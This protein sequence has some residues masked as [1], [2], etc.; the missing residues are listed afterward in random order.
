MLSIDNNVMVQANTGS[1]TA[2]STGDASIQTGNAYANA[3]VV[4][5]ANTN[6]VDSNYVMMV[7]NNYG[8]LNGDIVLPN[9]AFFAHFLAQAHAT[10]NSGTSVLSLDNNNQGQV[11]STV[12]T[13]AA[14]GNNS[15]TTTN[16]DGTTIQT[17]NSVSGS[18][19]VNQVNQNVVGGGNAVAIVFHVYGKWTGKTF[20]AP[21]Q[22]MW[23]G[24]PVSI[25]FF[26]DPAAVNAATDNL[27]NISSDNTATVNNNV[28]VNAG[29][30]N[31][32]AAGSGAGIQTGNAYANANILNI[33]NS[34][35]IGKNWINAIINIFGDWNGNI[36]FG[37]P[38][39][40][41][42]TRATF[43]DNYTGPQAKV[44]YHYTIKN[45]GDA[46]AHNVLL[47]H[48]IG[49]RWIVHSDV[50]QGSWAIGDVA[51]GQ[52]I[53]I[54]HKGEVTQGLPWAVTS[55]SNTIS[56]AANETD[57]DYRDNTD[58]V[59]VVLSY[60]AGITPVNYNPITESDVPASFVITKTNNSNGI[61][62]ASSTV[63]YTINIK[64]IGGKATNAHFID[65]IKDKDGVII[66]GE[67][68]DLDT[69]KSQEEIIITY[70]A[71]FSASTTPG[72]YTNSAYIKSV[73][74]SFTDSPVA[75]NSIIIVN[76]FL[77]KLLTINQ[78]ARP[79]SDKKSIKRVAPVEDAISTTTATTTATTTPVISSTDIFNP[80]SK[81]QVASAFAALGGQAWYWY[82][83]VI[84][85][86]VYL[87]YQQ[88]KM[89]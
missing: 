28:S 70:S 54:T 27:M 48:T 23:N 50:G 41:V 62:T 36:S 67:D 61:V 71:F 56:V 7:L 89:I 77:A 3:N 87:A 4:N 26:S 2:S 30:G 16:S 73:T 60:N 49:S 5:V 39:L 82:F 20:N 72:V 33:V 55:V 9:A 58:S 1:N 65:E 81:G 22:I 37:Q 79:L 52:V 13:T 78:R 11:T 84:A 38:N 31:N 46:P 53:E 69:I 14:T 75:K 57:S 80:P 43:A 83:L 63:D 42:G 40:W 12:T 21:E 64:N 29:T 45:L 51:P 8:N 59:N 24:T 74:G 17:G 76:P 68:W 47:N 6:F 19:V 15:A 34:N 32:N 88:R 86:A 10:S 44:T 85:G 66:H 25:Q 35:I 18:T